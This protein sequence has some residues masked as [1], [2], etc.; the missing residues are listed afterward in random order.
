MDIPLPLLVDKQGDVE[1]LSPRETHLDLQARSTRNT[2]NAI[3]NKLKDL[4]SRRD[5]PLAFED[6]EHYK[7]G[8]FFMYS[9]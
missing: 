2:L 8:F 6:V 7:V 9:H 4:K 3:R 1:T 5:T